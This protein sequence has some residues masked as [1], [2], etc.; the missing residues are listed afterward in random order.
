MKNEKQ[1]DRKKRGKIDPR[2]RVGTFVMEQN[3]AHQLAAA[4]NASHRNLRAG[5]FTRTGHKIRAGYGFC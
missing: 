5:F 2:R 3:F 4:S 1:A